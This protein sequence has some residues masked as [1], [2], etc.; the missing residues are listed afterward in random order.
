LSNPLPEPYNAAAE[1]WALMQEFTDRH[2]SRHRLREKLGM[3]LAKGRGKVKV[4]LLLANGPISLGEIADAQGIDRP[5]ATAIVDQLE[6]LGLVERTADPADRRRKLVALTAEGHRAVTIA[7][8]IMTTPPA[9]LTEL[10]PT[11]LTQL[12]GLLNRALGARP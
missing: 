12:A 11:E 1:V 9:P 10:T 5:Y 7:A 3:N 2:S 6:T 4:L 8:E